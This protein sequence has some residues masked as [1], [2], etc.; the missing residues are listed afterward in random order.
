MMILL[1]YVLPAYLI[2]IRAE[3]QMMCPHFGQAYDRYRDRVPGLIPGRTR[4]GRGDT[5]ARG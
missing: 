1:A 3:E 5:T 2:D 4:A